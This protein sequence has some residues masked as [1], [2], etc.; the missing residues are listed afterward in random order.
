MTN[1]YSLP[2][3]HPAFELLRRSAKVLHFTAATLIFINAWV[4]LRAGDMDN[5]V[6]YMEM[7]IA[8]DIFILVFFGGS[9]LPPRV[10]LLFR[11]IE[12]LALFGITVTLFNDHF[13]AAAFMH[14]A[15]SLFYAFLF[16]RE[17][18]VMYTVNVNI[19]H[20]GVTLPAFLKDA[21]ISWDNIKTV[22]PKYHS[23]LIETI[24]NRKINFELMKG[25]EIQE[26]AEIDEFCNQHLSTFAFS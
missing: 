24:N 15:A 5:F 2:V 12:A 1:H 26:M 25:L 9:D 18:K 16:Y 20:T 7:F 8:I 4:E 23:I 17:W 11:L 19:K 13:T 3:V 6:C 10:N 22:V 14:L 21:E